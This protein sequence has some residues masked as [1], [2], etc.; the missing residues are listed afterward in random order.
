[1]VMRIVLTDTVR[2]LHRRLLSSTALSRLYKHNG[3]YNTVKYAHK[4]AKA[5]RLLRVHKY[6][7]WA[8]YCCLD[9]HVWCYNMTRFGDFLSISTPNG[10]FFFRPGT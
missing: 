1:M 5:Y 8:Y 9:L 6:I 7:L 4:Q 3:N 2:L 10:L